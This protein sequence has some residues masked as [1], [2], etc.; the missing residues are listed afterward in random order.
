MGFPVVG[1]AARAILVALLEWYRKSELSSD[2][3][4]LLSIQDPEVAMMAMLKMA[5]GIPNG[6]TW[7]NEYNLDEFINQAEEY[8]TGGDVADQV[9]KVL[10]LMATTHPFWTLRLSEI[11]TWIENGDYDRIIRGEYARRG[12]ADPAYKDDLASA[13]K[14]YTEDAKGM[15][16]TMS[17]A[18][19][20]MSDSIKGGF[21]K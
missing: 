20:R 18:A 2:R 1:L 5:G 6:T 21:K 19:R 17:D 10:N 4:G 3:A 16:D 8:R 14:A 12:D 11:R 9:Y 15:M 13:A 7:Q